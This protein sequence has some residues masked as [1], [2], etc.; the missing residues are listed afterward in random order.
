[1]SSQV[2]TFMQNSS[3]I[4]HMEKR[5]KN[6]TFWQS[7]FNSQ[8]I[9]KVALDSLIAKKKMQKHRQDLKNMIM[10]SYGQAG[11]ED[12]IKTE[13]SIRKKRAELVHRKQ[14][15][16]DK[17]INIIAIIGLVITIVGFFVLLFFIW[18]ANKG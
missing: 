16:M 5:A 17:I 8:N 3:D 6:P 18:K 15:Q 10:M 7:M 9:E 11:W 14:E 4:E 12:F 2:S 1:M 13:I